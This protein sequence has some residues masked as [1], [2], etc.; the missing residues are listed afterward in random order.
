MVKKKKGNQHQS[1]VTLEFVDFESTFR[2][3]VLNSKPTRLKN[4]LDN[5]LSR[6]NV[7]EVKTMVPETHL[8]IGR[9]LS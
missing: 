4:C 2:L 9:L 8:S 7:N 5:I 6:F 1:I 3:N